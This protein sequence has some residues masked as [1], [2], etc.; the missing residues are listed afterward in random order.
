MSCP[1]EGC[2]ALSPWSG[3]CRFI[4]NGELAKASDPTIG[5]LVGEDNDYRRQLGGTGLG[6]IEIFRRLRKKRRVIVGKTL[7]IRI[8]STLRSE[9]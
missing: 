6:P 1:K 3:L 9:G 2:V 7:Q 8:K 4:N 5:C